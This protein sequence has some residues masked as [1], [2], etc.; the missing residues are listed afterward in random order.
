MSMTTLRKSAGVNG[1]KDLLN[2][3][4]MAQEFHIPASRG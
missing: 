3:P 4:L 2:K 1:L